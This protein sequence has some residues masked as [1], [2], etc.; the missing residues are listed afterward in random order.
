MK[1]LFI[2]DHPFPP[3]VRVE[4]EMKALTDA[5]SDVHVACVQKDGE[6]LNE[7][8][9]YGT[10]HR[11]PM[12]K[13]I[14]KSSVGVLKFPFYFNYWRRFVDELFAQEHFDAIHICDLPLAR[15][16]Y[17][18]KIKYG[19]IFVLDLFE[20][21]PVLLQ[22]STHTN[23]FLG[24]MLSS[25]RQ[26][27]RYEKEMCKLADRVIVVIEE[28]KTRIEALGISP[29]K[30]VV[31]SNTLDIEQFDVPK[32]K[33]F[34]TNEIRMLYVGGINFH[35]GIQYV[36]KAISILKEKNVPVHFDLVGSGSYLANI[37][38]LIEELKV[39]DNVTVHGYKPYT[40]ICDLYETANIA[41]IPHVK[42]SHTDNTIPNK[43]FQYMYAEIPMVVSNCDPLVRIMD[44]TG[45]GLS[46]HYDQP[47]ELAAIIADF[48]EHPEKLSCYIKHGRK[49]VIDKY[50]WKVD[51]CKLVE[52]YSCLA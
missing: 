3:N 12:S 45:S 9:I 41:L 25:H 50:N 4:N 26:W 28:A 42:S 39:Q 1:I 6:P 5:G 35:R 8:T 31:I 30:V 48:Y 23:T 17:K 51:G 14:Y 49:A 29:E 44:E 33:M 19:T 21:W 13:F 27:V 18:A 38:S 10:V 46:Y 11:K 52:F 32:R 34:N 15:I 20:N 2:L 16:G 22:L 40:Q 7:K 24:K 47:E 43:I 36:I 37:K